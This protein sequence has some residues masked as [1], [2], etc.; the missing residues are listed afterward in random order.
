MVFDELDKQCAN[1]FSARKSAL[2]FKQDIMNQ[3]NSTSNINAIEETNYYYRPFSDNYASE[4]GI[5]MICKI[6]IEIW[7]ILA[8]AHSALAHSCVLLYHTAT[9]R[10]NNSISTSKMQ[11]LFDTQRERTMTLQRKM[12]E[13][14]KDI[15]NFP[16]MEA[17]EALRDLRTRLREYIIAMQ[18]EIIAPSVKSSSSKKV[19][20]LSSPSRSTSTSGG[21]LVSASRPLIFGDAFGGSSHVYYPTPLKQISEHLEF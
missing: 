5:G 19:N 4:N 20:Q 9:H 13:D 6:T 8:E 10:G 12:D 16:I 14:W 18:S 11:F 7:Q 21:H 15:S 2:K 3:M 1:Y 17:K